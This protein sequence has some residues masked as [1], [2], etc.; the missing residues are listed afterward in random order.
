MYL[1]QRRTY[2]FSLLLRTLTNLLSLS[3]RTFVT[4]Q[5][6]ASL[7]QRTFGTDELTQSFTKDLWHRRTYSVFHK[8]PSSQTNL[9]PV[10]HKGPSVHELTQSFTKDLR[11]RPTYCQSFTKDLWHRRTY[12]VFHKG[13]ASE[14]FWSRLAY[15]DSI[16]STL[17]SFRHAL[18][19]PQLTYRSY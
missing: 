16:R 11:H 5:L 2:Q 10:F 9:L 8:G 3:Q 17:S 4:D 13:P 1:C 19:S 18:F 12:S 7:S 14:T 6:T 15:F